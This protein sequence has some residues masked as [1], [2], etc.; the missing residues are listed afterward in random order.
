MWW[1]AVF[2]HFPLVLQTADAHWNTLHYRLYTLLYRLYYIN[3][4]SNQ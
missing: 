4:S 3:Y 1:L 2:S